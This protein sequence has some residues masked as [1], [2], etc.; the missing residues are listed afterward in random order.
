MTAWDSRP[1][2]GSA[3]LFLS[4]AGEL[5]SLTASQEQ[6]SLFIRVPGSQRGVPGQGAPVW[7]LGLA[8][9]NPRP[10]SSLPLSVLGDK[11]QP[12]LQG[13]PHLR[14]PTTTPCPGFS[15]ATGVLTLQPAGKGWNG[16]R[17]R[18]NTRALRERKPGALYSGEKGRGLG[19]GGKGATVRLD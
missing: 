9:Q 5:W 15:L 17:R 7:L 2:T 16:G 1:H 4:G 3:T 12:F 6:T 13:L 10:L 11:T 19:E 18:G 8:V 14:G